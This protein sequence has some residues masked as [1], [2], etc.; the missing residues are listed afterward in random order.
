MASYGGKPVPVPGGDWRGYARN[1]A[2]DYGIPENLFDA[3][4]EGESSY[5]PYAVGRLGEIGLG[6]LMPSTAAALGV[7]PWNPDENLT[8][9]AKYLRQQFDAS[10]NWRDALAAYKG[11]PGNYANP[12]PQSAADKV[13]RAAGLDP[14]G[15]EKQAAQWSWLDPW[16]W[17]KARGLDIGA[18]V[19]GAALILIGLWSLMSPGVQRAASAG[20][21][22]G[23]A[24]GLREGAA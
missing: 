7:D 20:F 13:L 2:R 9:A 14:Q 19:L 6:Q 23:V 15:A 10:G 1:L 22:E 21:R 12:G 17:L 5:N 4:I 16:P 3:L 11:G 18:F 24:R 8:G